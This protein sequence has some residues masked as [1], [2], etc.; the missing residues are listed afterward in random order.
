MKSELT[1]LESVAPRQLLVNKRAVL[2]RALRVRNKSE[3]CNDRNYRIWA[4]SAN[5]AA[6]CRVREKY[7][8]GQSVQPVTA[9]QRRVC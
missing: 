4:A 1:G 7:Q 6:G 3:D 5:T 9:K 2:A 8:V